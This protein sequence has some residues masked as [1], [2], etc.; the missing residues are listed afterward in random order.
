MEPFCF[1]SAQTSH[2][3]DHSIAQVRFWKNYFVFLF[4]Y[5]FG[6]YFYEE[7]FLPCNF[8]SLPFISTL[9]ISTLLPPSSPDIC[10]KAEESDSQRKGEECEVRS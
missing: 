3:F 7:S 1:H 5:L 2:E 10:F 8:L 9:T 6:P 4:I